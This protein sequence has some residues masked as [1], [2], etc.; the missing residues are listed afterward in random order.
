MWHAHELK[1]FM[2]K[3]EWKRNVFYFSQLSFDFNFSRWI[4]KWC[5]FQLMCMSHDTYSNVSGLGQAAYIQGQRSNFNVGRTGL[6][7]PSFWGWNIKGSWA[8]IFLIG[9][10]NN[11]WAGI[12]LSSRTKWQQTQTWRDQNVSWPNSSKKK[13]VSWPKLLCISFKITPSRNR[14]M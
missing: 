1:F 13:K 7:K 12:L 8:G 6:N 3:I 14:L 10:N 4:I 11:S 2:E 9:N 5:L